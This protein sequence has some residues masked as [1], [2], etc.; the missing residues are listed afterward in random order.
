LHRAALYAQ[1]GLWYDAV[2][3]AAEGENADRHAALDALLDQVGLTEPAGYDRSL[4]A[5]GR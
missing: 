3:A 1:A 5:G 4:A 2:A